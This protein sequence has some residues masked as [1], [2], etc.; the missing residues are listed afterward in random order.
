[1][2]EIDSDKK[3]LL[4]STIDLKKLRKK[5]KKSKKLKFKRLKEKKIY[6]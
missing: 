5:L 1:M 3:Q 2:I 6:E 4:I